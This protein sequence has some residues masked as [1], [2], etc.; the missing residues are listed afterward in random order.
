ML[1]SNKRNDEEYYKSYDRHDKKQSQMDV[2][3]E[4][5][6][7]SLKNHIIVCEF[8]SSIQHFILP[9]RAKY[10]DKKKQQI[11]IITP[12]KTIP[13]EIWNTIDRFK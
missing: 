1:L 9:L 2:S 8:H 4:S 10:L 5:H 3:E 13:E 11:V 12:I 6:L 7:A